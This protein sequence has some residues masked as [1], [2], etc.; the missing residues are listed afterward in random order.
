[1]KRKRGETNLFSIAREAEQTKR[2][3]FVNRTHLPGASAPCELLRENKRP[4][5]R[6]RNVVVR[7]AFLSTCTSRSQ[8]QLQYNLASRCKNLTNT[9]QEVAIQDVCINIHDPKRITQ[10]TKHH[11]HQRPKYFDRN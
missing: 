8:V 6:R 3:A 2:S 11:L 5:K 10:K 7:E 1:V 9:R 4:T